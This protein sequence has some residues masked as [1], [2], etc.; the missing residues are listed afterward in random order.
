M[1]P[2]DEVGEP[3]GMQVGGHHYGRTDERF[4]RLVGVKVTKA[5]REVMGWNQPMLEDEGVGVVA[6]VSSTNDGREVLLITA[7]EEP[8][9]PRSHIL[10]GAP[11]QCSRANL[12]Q[13]HGGKRPPR[14]DLLD[15][16]YVQWS[17][18]WADGGRYFT[19]AVQYSKWPALV[20]FSTPLNDNERW[21]TR[22]E[23]EAAIVA[24]EV[25]EHLRTAYLVTMVVPRAAMVG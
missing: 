21:F 17:E 3:W 19:K 1:I 16:S 2:L 5:G 23:L 15:G 18:Q 7:R 22:K 8:G 11:I 25:N 14:V 4:F 9:N 10:L 24:G 13:A 12:D 20:D 6:L